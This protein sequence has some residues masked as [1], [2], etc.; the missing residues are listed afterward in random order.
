MSRLAGLSLTSILRRFFRKEPHPT[1]NEP[2]AL[3]ESLRADRKG[4]TDAQ[5]H[6]YGD[7]IDGDELDPLPFVVDDQ[8]SFK[9]DLAEP[10]QTHTTI[11]Q[12][13]LPIARRMCIV[14][15][16]APARDAVTTGRNRITESSGSCECRLLEVNMTGQALHSPLPFERN[17]LISVQFSAPNTDGGIELAGTV[18]RCEPSRRGGFQIILRLERPLRSAE[19]REIGRDLFASAIV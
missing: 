12:D 13:K 14:R 19:I 7:L 4:F 18:V 10:N 2:R 5:L 15:R 17:S 6:P 16:R 9:T 3:R 1:A 11:G 8:S